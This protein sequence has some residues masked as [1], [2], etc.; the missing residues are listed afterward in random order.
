MAIMAFMIALSALGEDIPQET[1]FFTNYTVVSTNGTPL[2]STNEKAAAKLGSPRE[3]L[4]ELNY[5][6]T[7][8]SDSFLPNTNGSIQVR[9][10]GPNLGGYPRWVGPNHYG[11]FKVSLKDEHGVSV[12]PTR[13][14]KKLGRAPQTLNPEAGTINSHNNITLDFLGLDMLEELTH[15]DIDDMFVIHHAGN[16]ELK[17]TP[18]FYWQSGPL[19][20]R[21]D[22]TNLPPIAATIPLKANDSFAPE[23]K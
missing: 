16:Y 8:R 21:I 11:I 14:G 4:L 5:F 2:V 12:E 20:R 13:E 7:W 3:M 18:Q 6:P 15:F 17:M 10:S 19:L 23:Q 1:V 22:L 9:A